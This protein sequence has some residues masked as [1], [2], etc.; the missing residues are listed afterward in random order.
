MYY[1]KLS[2]ILLFISCNTQEVVEAEDSLLVLNSD[3]SVEQLVEDLKSEIE[4]NDLN[5]FSVIEH[6]KAAEKAGMELLPTT[7]IL[8][9][10]P[11][12]G[13]QLMQCDQRMGMELPLKLLVWKGT[14]G[15]SHVGIWRMGRYAEYYELHAC[16]ELLPKINNKIQQIVNSALQD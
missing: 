11:K 4:R 2:L 12:I 1:L 7:L 3:K 15:L 14:N 8:F 5:V 10:D 9:G 13:T 16:E 6:S